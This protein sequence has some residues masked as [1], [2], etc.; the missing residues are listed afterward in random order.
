MRLS[1][2]AAV[3]ALACV[4][5]APGA[6]PARGKA[7]YD[8]RCGGC[9]TIAENGPGPRHQGLFG[10]RAG[11]QP[12][13]AYSEALRVSGIVW[14]DAMLDRWLADPNALVPGN[15]MVVQLAPLATERVDLIAFLRTA[16]QGPR[17]CR[18]SN[19]PTP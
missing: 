9:H 10:C 12:G 19:A 4:T 7:L 14:N 15:A 17:T 18:R 11:T 3:I 5:A 16:A 13:Y 6:D 2:L 1:L 8:A